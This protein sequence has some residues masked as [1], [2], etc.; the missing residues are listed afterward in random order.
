VVLY[1][2]ALLKL[3][4]SLIR[5]MR[6]QFFFSIIA[7]ALQTRLTYCKSVAKVQNTVYCMFCKKW[8]DMFKIL[9]FISVLWG[10]F[11]FLNCFVTEESPFTNLES[12]CATPNTKN[13]YVV[14]IL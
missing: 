10:V 4:L 3:P 13:C 8:K 7:S 6:Y 12:E 1:D 14:C 2:S 5:N 9:K 11:S